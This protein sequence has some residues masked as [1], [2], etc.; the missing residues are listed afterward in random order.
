MSPRKPSNLAAS[1]RQRLT[2]IAHERGDDF[3]L[4]LTRYMIRASA[5][6]LQSF[7]FYLHHQRQPCQRTILERPG[8]GVP[9][10]VF[11]LKNELVPNIR[12]CNVAGRRRTRTQEGEPR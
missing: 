1:V 12:I 3:Q 4:V 8:N 10:P 6:Y 11:G 7:L 9:I 2:N 5:L